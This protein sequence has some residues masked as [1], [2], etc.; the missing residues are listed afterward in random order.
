MLI[1]NLESLIF[2]VPQKFKLSKPFKFFT[3]IGHF[4]ASPARSR[5]AVPTAR[6]KTSRSVLRQLLGASSPMPMPLHLHRPLQ[7]RGAVELVRRC[8]LGNVDDVDRKASR[9]PVVR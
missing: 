6:E 5:H 3:V 8:R 4:S 2:P 1:A 7:Q 9:N